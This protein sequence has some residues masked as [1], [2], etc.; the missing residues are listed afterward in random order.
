[1]RPYLREIPGRKIVGQV[2][3][4][5]SLWGTVLECEQGYRA[6]HAYPLRIYVPLDSARPRRLRCEELAAGL[7]AYAV[8]VELVPARGAEAI[9]LF[10]QTLPS[11]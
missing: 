1:M 9:E 10:E 5:V 2:F 4:R 7:D 8:P 11:R 6:S 3:G